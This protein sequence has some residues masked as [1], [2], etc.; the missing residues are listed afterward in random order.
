MPIALTNRPELAA[1]RDVI[2]AAEETVRREKNRP[3]LPTVYLTGFQSPGQ[4]RMQGE[5]FGLGQGSKMNNWS[6]RNDVSMQLIWSL[7]GLGLGNL[8]RIKQQRGVQSRTIVDLRAFKTPSSPMS[9]A[10]KLIS[11]PPRC[12]CSK[13]SDQC[14]RHSSLS[15]AITRG[16]LKPNASRTC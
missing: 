14:A 11:S 2:R 8:A 5:V 16:W 13:P 7:D 6:L 1:Q 3:L 15:T 10:P 4:M 12:A 9:M